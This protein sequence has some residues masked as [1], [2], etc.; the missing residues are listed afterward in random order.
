MDKEG[1]DGSGVLILD[2]GAVREGPHP[3]EG[4]IKSKVSKEVRVRVSYEYLEGEHSKQRD[5]P[6][7]RP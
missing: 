4:D 6:V 3:R 7:Q 2:E 1:R 5:Q